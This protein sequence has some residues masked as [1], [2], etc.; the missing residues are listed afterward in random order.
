MGQRRKAR[1][2]AVQC[3]YALDFAEVKADFREYGLL[4]EYPEMLRQLTSAEN[5]SPSSPVFAFAD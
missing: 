1:E 5:I 2:M 3:I 4:N